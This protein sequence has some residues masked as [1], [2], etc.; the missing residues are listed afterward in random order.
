[1]RRLAPSFAMLIACGTAGTMGARLE[2]GSQAW[3]SATR[4]R[5]LEFDSDGSGALEAGEVERLP[6]EVLMRPVREWEE[7]FGSSFTASH[8]LGPGLLFRGGPLG[9]DA[10]GASAVASLEQRCGLAEVASTDDTAS[11]LEQLESPPTSAEWDAKVATILIA[12]HDLDRSGSIDSRLEIQ[13]ISCEVF[14]E[15]DRQVRGVADVG[16]ATLYGVEPGLVW[17]GPALGFGDAVRDE[18]GERLVECE[19][20]GDFD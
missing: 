10:S 11:L 7:A 8:G 15:L 4:A 2:T 20:V 3:L 6:C 14:A 17:I 16:V 1:M 18:L 19:L 5:L 13:D 9:F 12:G